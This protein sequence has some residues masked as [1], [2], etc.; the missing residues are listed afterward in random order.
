MQILTEKL[1]QVNGSEDT[2][3]RKKTSEEEKAF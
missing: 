3:R 1:K 2:D